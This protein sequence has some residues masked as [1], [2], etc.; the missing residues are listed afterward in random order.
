[1]LNRAKLNGVA[2]QKKGDPPRNPEFLHHRF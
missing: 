1:M 2:L